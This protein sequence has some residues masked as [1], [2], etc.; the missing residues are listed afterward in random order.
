MKKTQPLVTLP[1]TVPKSAALTVAREAVK[2]VDAIPKLLCWAVL[3]ASA[4]ILIIQIW[5]YF[6]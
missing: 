6:L 5:T 2:I 3:G 4:A 1:E